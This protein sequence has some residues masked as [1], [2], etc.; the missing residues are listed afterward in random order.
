VTQT[1]DSIVGVDSESSGGTFSNAYPIAG[2]VTGKAVTF[3]YTG[4]GTYKGTFAT[5]DSVAGY[6]YYDASDS[7]TLVWKKQ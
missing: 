4:Y 3:T 7:T 1:G 6:Y 2:N 5:Q